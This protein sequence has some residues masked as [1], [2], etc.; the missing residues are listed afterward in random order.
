MQ[1]PRCWGAGEPPFAGVGGVRLAVFAPPGGP[2]DGVFD[3]H[4]ARLAIDVDELKNYVENLTQT[5]NG[6]K[7]HTGT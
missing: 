7:Q 3:A 1:L 5:C 4:G 6:S 2:L